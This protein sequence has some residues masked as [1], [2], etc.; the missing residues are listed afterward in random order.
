MKLLLT[1]IRRSVR[2]AV[3]KREDWVPIWACW[4]RKKSVRYQSVD[5]EDIAAIHS[6]NPK[7][8]LK[9]PPEYR[10]FKKN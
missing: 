1:D 4:L 3:L 8:K 9:G 6:R 7:S 5:V 2:G 10:F